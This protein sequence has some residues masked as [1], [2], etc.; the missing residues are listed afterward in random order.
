MHVGCKK[1]EKRSNTIRL[2]LRLCQNRMFTFTLTNA[3]KAERSDTLVFEKDLVTTVMCNQQIQSQ[4]QCFIP[5]KQ[6][7]D[8]DDAG[9]IKLNTQIFVTFCQHHH[10]QQF[11][12]KPSTMRP[13]KQTAMAENTFYRC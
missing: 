10:S 6:Y 8:Y 3:S 12:A 13:N 7:V 5:A 2:L 1:N 11:V 9:K 4:S